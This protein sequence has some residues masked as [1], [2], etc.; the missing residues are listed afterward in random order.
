MNVHIRH[1]NE[2]KWDLCG[3]NQGRWAGLSV[4][5]RQSLEFTQNGAKN[6][7]KK[8]ILCAEGL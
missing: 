6:K 8:S 1:Q 7:N 5:A 2:E 3:F 4:H